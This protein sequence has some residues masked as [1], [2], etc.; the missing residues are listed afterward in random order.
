[1]PAQNYA[2]FII[3]SKMDY[4]PI[5]NATEEPADDPIDDLD[6]HANLSNKEQFGSLLVGEPSRCPE[7]SK[8]FKERTL[9]RCDY[10]GFSYGYLEKLLPVDQLPPLEILLDYSNRLANN[11]KKRIL[12]AITF[13]QKRYPQFIPKVCLLPL[14]PDVEVHQMALWMINQC[15][16]VEGETKQ[17]KE[18]YVLLLIDTSKSR[19]CLTYGYQAEIFIPDDSSEKLV[20]TLNQSLKKN[21]I[22]DPII[23]LLDDIVPI[24]DSTKR[25]LK[26]EYKR[27]K[28]KN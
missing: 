23:E 27:F 9:A 2:V 7:C 12:E 16:V 21:S 11:E 22:G 4:E 8:L 15:P 10:C 3:T 28:R 13:I 14:Q 17:D 5:N 20:S 1:M 26:R 24:L 19:C 18:W 6:P 25:M